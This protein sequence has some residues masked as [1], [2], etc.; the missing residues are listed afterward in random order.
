MDPLGGRRRRTAASES[1]GGWMK[2]CTSVRAR[3][4][5]SRNRTVVPP[6]AATVPDLL[7]EEI[8]VEILARLPVKSLLCFKSVCRG[9]RAIISEPSFIRTQLQCSAS[10]QEPSILISPHTL[11]G[12]C[13]IQPPVGGLGDWPNNFSTQISFYQWQR[14][15]SIARFMDATA[16]PANEFH[17]VCHFAHCDGL[18]LAPTDTNLYLF[19][20]ATRDT[21]TLPDGHGD[22]HHHGTEMEA[23]YAAGLG[24]D[25][26]TRKYKVV[27]AFYRSVDPIRM[28]MEVFTVGETGAGCG[29]RETVTDPPYPVSRWLTAFTVN[30]GYLFW[31]MD[32][33]RY[34]NDTL[35]GG[36]LWFSLQDQAFGVTLLPHSLDPALDDKVRPDV[37]HGELCV[38]H[39]NSD[40]MTVTIWTT[41]SPSFDD[42]ERRYC[43]YVSRLCHPM[44]LLG[45]GGMLLWAK[46]TIHRY[47]LW[48]DEL[49]A[50]CELGGIRYQ[51]GRPP[52]WKNLFNF[53]VMPY[54]ESLR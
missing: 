36:L 52:R 9:W 6:A 51:G 7:P 27:R 4:T 54:T 15:A 42:W 8:V 23:C 45:D 2:G 25:P 3:D 35:H 46:H 49:T 44:G 41:N 12:R 5:R 19:N 50:V 43:I 40:T 38:L 30:G 28:G 47:D 24:L 53:S 48:S 37:L 29:W 32:R 31:Y 14:G 10:K 22:N 26:V 16:I 33:F 1:G 11:L 34:P 39:A 13:D 21:I 17:L 18:V 20:P